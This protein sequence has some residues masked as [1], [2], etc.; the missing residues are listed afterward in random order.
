MNYQSASLVYWMKYARDRVILPA[1]V[2]I[3]LT[4]ACNQ[5]CFY[6]NSAEHRAARPGGP[7]ADVYLS[8]LDKLA[9]WR[10][11]SPNSIGT[12]HT[13]TY[14]GGGEPTLLKGFERVI[15]HTIDL[16]FLTALTTNGYRLDKLISHVP[17]EKLRKMAWIGID[18]DAGSK[19]LYETIRKSKTKHS[20]F[21]RVVT[22]AKNLIGL[23]V[24][25]DIKILLCGPNLNDKAIQDIFNL[26][27]QI[28]PR[29][30]YFR[31]A[32]INNRLVD[33][34]ESIK[35]LILSLS[36]KYNQKI[37][38]ESSR[39]EKRTYNRC[40]QMY[41]FP[42]FCADGYIYSCCENK[43]NVNFSIGRWDN[44]DFR[45]LWLGDQHNKIYNETNTHLCK[46]CRPNR[47]NNSIQSILN[48]PEQ[49]ES[50][51]L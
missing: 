45:D 28:K 29:L 40:H 48:N 9:T 34:P 51:F 16:G 3:D 41:Q 44:D 42:V 37:K 33:V 14:P 13:V 19:E 50:L 43:G 39:Q 47:S 6:C 18:M 46:P 5:D 2:D 22:N 24:N 21:D 32:V 20:I 15:E 17:H 12:L 1:S 10:Q 4:N 25:V 8:L 35:D 36:I 49:I 31:T 27:D 7:K 38:L 23:G 26:M 11:H 30:V